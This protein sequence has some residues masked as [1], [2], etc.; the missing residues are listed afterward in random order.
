MNDT[1]V[2]ATLFPWIEKLVSVDHDLLIVNDV[3]AEINMLVYERRPD[4]P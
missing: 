1:I 2:L 3:L 4:W